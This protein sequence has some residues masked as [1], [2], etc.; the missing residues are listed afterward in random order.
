MFKEHDVKYVDV[1]GT[2]KGRGFTGAMKAAVSTLQSLMGTMESFVGST[3]G[4]AII[5]FGLLT[6][7]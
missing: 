2:T 3:L 5:Q 7:G 6:A 1:V 4:G